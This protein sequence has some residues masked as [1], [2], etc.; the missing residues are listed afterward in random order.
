M[1]FKNFIKTITKTE[2][3]DNVKKNQKTRGKIFLYFCDPELF[4]NIILKQIFDGIIEKHLP[5]NFLLSILMSYAR[6][7]YITRIII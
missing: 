4:I 6:V 2:P 1:F 7:H 3:N 5:N